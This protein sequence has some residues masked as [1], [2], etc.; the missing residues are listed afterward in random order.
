[1]QRHIRLLHNFCE[2]AIGVAF[3]RKFA[4]KRKLQHPYLLLLCRKVLHVCLQELCQSFAA[5]GVALVAA[6]FLRSLMPALNELLVRLAQIAV[7]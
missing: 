5:R 3:E 6:R 2:I 1:M 4:S 7:L